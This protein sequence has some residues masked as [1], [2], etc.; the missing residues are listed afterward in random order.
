MP[1]TR[2]ARR[3]VAGACRRCRQR[4]RCSSRGCDPGAR[5]GDDRRDERVEIGGA[6]G[7][8]PRGASAAAGSQPAFRRS[9]TCMSAR[10][11]L[12][13]SA[14]FT[15]PSFI[16]FDRGSSTARMRADPTARAKGRRRSSRWPS[17]GARRIVVDGNASAIPRVS[18]RR[19]MPSIRPRRESCRRGDPHVSRPRE[20]G[21]RVQRLCR[22]SCGRSAASEFALAD[23]GASHR[24]VVVDPPFGNVARS[25]RAPGAPIP[26]RRNV[27][28]RTSSRAP[29]HGREAGASAFTTA[30]P[31]AE[32]ERTR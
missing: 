31:T 21:E 20:H 7:F 2:C 29:A 27:R 8:A 4:R 24:A 11:R 19:R 12:P 10:A 15:A 3:A 13:G 16:V 6:R 32:T 17:D 30:G 26:R 5:F 22:P 9:R 28:P 23:A 14:F 1:P 18:S 25:E